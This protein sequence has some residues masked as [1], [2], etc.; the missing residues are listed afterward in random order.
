L[1]TVC[2]ENG[3][4]GLSWGGELK[5]LL[6]SD[7]TR[8]TRRSEG[9]RRG[10]LTGTAIYPLLLRVNLE[11][12]NLKALRAGEAQP[13]RASSLLRALRVKQSGTDFHGGGTL[14]WCA[15][16]PVEPLSAAT[17]QQAAKSRSSP[18]KGRGFGVTSPSPTSAPDN[19]PYTTSA[20]SPPAPAFPPPQ[21]PRP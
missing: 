7:F 21:S 8:R 9:T 4:P 10:A 19:A 2:R 12:A 13:L 6:K 1:P 17:R 3:V 15:K 11:G 20:L 18:L 5:T 14:A 16:L